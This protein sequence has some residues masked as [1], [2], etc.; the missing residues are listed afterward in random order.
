MNRQTTTITDGTG[1]PRKLIPA[2]EISI[3]SSGE[4]IQFQIGPAGQIFLCL[5][6]FLLLFWLTITTAVTLSERIGVLETA[7][8]DISSSASESDGRSESFRRLIES[9]ESLEQQ[10]AAALE[11]ADI[12]L[13]DKMQLEL[14]LAELSRAQD[15][16][17]ES[18]IPAHSETPPGDGN[19]KV[20]RL[21]TALEAAVAD[22]NTAREE[23]QVQKEE[24]STLVDSAEI[25]REK[26]RR[27]IARLTGAVTM[28]SDGLESLFKRL[29][30][31]P[32]QLTRD[33][34]AEYSGA[35]GLAVNIDGGDDGAE[36]QYFRDSDIQEALEAV[37]ELNV[38]K[39]A[40]HSLPIGHPVKRVNRFTSGFG[41]RIHPVHKRR[42]FHAGADF[43]APSGTP[44][45]A[46]GGGVVTFVGRKGAYGQTV[47]IRHA[48][49][50]EAL[51]AHLSK[52][53]VK[54]DERVW[55]NQH[56]ADMGSTGVST[57][58]H[59]HYEVRL[60][61]QAVNPMQFI[62]AD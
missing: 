26:A 56:I 38:N 15:A 7:E 21:L 62:K 45:H 10:V 34:K 24:N 9:T 4:S 61:D 47:V 27:T 41:P 6:A 55:R 49:G 36:L 52:I 48:G 1:T 60:G 35:G 22:L 54:L 12:T 5:A 33:I 43:A 20:E 13:V 32:E 37:D 57:A 29:G 44:I 50:V 2:R 31:D 28:A 40:H 14:S 51:Y 46:T 16:E 39:L 17:S 42:D 11:L 58:P 59:L 30:L 3:S 53:R 23:L 18:A 25:S 8:Q 19:A